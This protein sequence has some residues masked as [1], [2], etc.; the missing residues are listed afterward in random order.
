MIKSYF[1]TA[2]RNLLNHRSF[3]AINIFGLSVSMAVCMLI[4]L[5]LQD[6]FSYDNFHKN[7]DRIFRIQSK[8]NLSKVSLTKYASATWPLGKELKDNY[9][10][11][12]EMAALNN[13]YNEEG[14]YDNKRFSVSVLFATPSFFDIFDFK[15]TGNLASNPLN[16]PN[17]IVI[18]EE[19]AAKF[20][21]DK[22]PIGKT[23]LFERF[24][25]LTV[26]GV[27][28]KSRQKSHIQFEALISASTLLPLEK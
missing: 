24:G 8:D 23:I 4:I 14:T 25:T 27:I 13:R 15:V 2:I 28:P 21:G 18:T 1:L 22:D 5:I 26:T 10:I 12:K 20:F 19:L 6:Q 3:S 16:E 17:S 7:R 9:P 11:I